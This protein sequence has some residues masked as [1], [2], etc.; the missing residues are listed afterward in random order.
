MLAVAEPF[1][2]GSGNTL[3]PARITNINSAWKISEHTRSLISCLNQNFFPK[4]Q[5]FTPEHLF[6]SLSDPEDSSSS[7]EDT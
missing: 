6:Y 5:A 3:Q 7:E 2:C 1:S 4:Q